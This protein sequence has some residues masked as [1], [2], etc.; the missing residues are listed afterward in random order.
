MLRAI[1]KVG[2]LEATEAIYGARGHTGQGMSCARA[3]TFVSKT[4][5][6]LVRKTTQEL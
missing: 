5:G 6:L 4:G 3:A 2:L 1:K